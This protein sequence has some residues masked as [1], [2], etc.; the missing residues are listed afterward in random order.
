ME[1]LGLLLFIGFGIVGLIFNLMHL[2][3]F[4][5]HVHIYF[6]RPRDEHNEKRS[7]NDKED[8]RC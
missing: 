1:A 8:D 7:R 5:D 6:W 3:N 4:M 2:A